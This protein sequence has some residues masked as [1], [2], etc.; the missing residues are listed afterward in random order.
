MNHSFNVEVAKE[1]GVLAA[2]VFNNIGFWVDNARANGNNEHDGRF[3]TYNSVKAWAEQFPYASNGQIGR[4]L[5]K[6]REAGYVLT[7]NYNKNPYDHTL[8]YALSD[9]GEAV[10]YAKNRFTEEDNSI[11]Q[12]RKMEDSFSENDIK[13]NTNPD[14]NPDVCSPARGEVVEFMKARGASESYASRFV[15]YYQAQGWKRSNGAAIT[16]WK[17]LA[18]S[19]LDKDGIR[20]KVDYPST[21][22]CACG[23][24]MDKTATFKSGTDVPFYRCMDC[25]AMEAWHD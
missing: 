24:T 17:A 6:L 25:N 16:D 1:V 2:T 14:A 15:G 19:W 23:G 9:K 4:A 8:W 11:L 12:K 5:A 13:T 10:F 7:G 18:E 22:A 21:M 3:W 20:P